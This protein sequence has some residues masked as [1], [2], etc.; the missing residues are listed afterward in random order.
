MILNSK[1]LLFMTRLMKFPLRYKKY[2]KS[3]GPGDY[4]MD[5]FV[6]HQVQVQMLG[7]W[8]VSRLHHQRHEQGG[9]DVEGGGRGQHHS[10]HG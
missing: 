9:E 7:R 8:A 5:F 4:R 6:D 1:L 3:L 2:D 10:R